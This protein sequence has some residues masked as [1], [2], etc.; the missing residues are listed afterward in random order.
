MMGSLMALHF[1]AARFDPIDY[2]GFY[3]LFEELPP[4]TLVMVVLVISAA[5]GMVEEAAYRGTMQR[6]IERRHGRVVA[7]VVVAFFFCAVH[8][9]SIPPLTVTRTLF[10]FAASVG[11]S[12]LVYATGSILPGVVL[13]FVGDA[14]GIFILWWLWSLGGSGSN[15]PLWPYIAESA[16]LATISVWAFRKLKRHE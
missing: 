8:I 12:V 5:A 7:T 2:R 9:T 6:M 14:A 15:W 13:H 4:Q 10:I 3:A 11:Y 1:V 16:I